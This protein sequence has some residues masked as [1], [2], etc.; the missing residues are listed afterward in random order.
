MNSSTAPRPTTAAPF[1]AA[2]DTGLSFIDF[3]SERLAS[4]PP[5]TKGQRTRERLKIAAARV[6]EQKGYHALRVA[7]VAEAAEVA[8]GSFYVYFRDKTEVT[9]AV[10][11]SLLEDFFGVNLTSQS[12][13]GPFDTIRRTNRR[14]FAICRS[15]SGLMRCMLQVG[16][17]DPEFAQMAQNSNR[18]WY[19]RIAASVTR[20]YPEGALSEPLVLLVAYMLGAIMDDLARKLVVY[21][22]EGLLALLGQL[23]ANDVVAADAASV[24]WMRTLYPGVPIDGD[25]HAVARAIASWP[26]PVVA[27]AR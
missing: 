7:D 17:A 26:S 19:E 16:D 4:A 12:D 10:L 24:L 23:G 13:E 5:P 11:T 27:G 15:N 18:R 21:P 20:R 1:T 6:L 8:E 2:A 25:L 14:W 9:L 3:L 22:D